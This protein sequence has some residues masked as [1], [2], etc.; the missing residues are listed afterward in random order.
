[1]FL[2]YSV[3]SSLVG[4]LMIG[5]REI[6]RRRFLCQRETRLNRAIRVMASKQQGDNAVQTPKQ[7][8][9]SRT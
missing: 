3:T 9:R 4:I 2:M 7:V 5:L 1:M 8:E 6:K